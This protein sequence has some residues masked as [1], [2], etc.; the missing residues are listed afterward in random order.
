MGAELYQLGSNNSNINQYL[1]SQALSLYSSLERK[2]QLACEQTS[3][4]PPYAQS[5]MRM[6]LNRG[7]GQKFCAHALV[8]LNLSRT[9]PQLFPP[10]L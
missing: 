7:R 9:K 1:H 2:T 10:P 4:D 8:L 3:P 5:R 6:T